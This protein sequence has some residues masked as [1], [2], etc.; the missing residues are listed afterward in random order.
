MDNENK[1]QEE[2]KTEAHKSFERALKE[3]YDIE[4]DENGI[5]K[6]EHVGFKIK[7]DFSKKL[8]QYLDTKPMMESEIWCNDIENMLAD[9]DSYL[10]REFMQGFIKYL[11]EKCP[12]SEVKE[13]VAELM[14]EE[15]SP[16]EIFI[17]HKNKNI[18]Q[19]EIV[20]MEFMVAEMDA[21]QEEIKKQNQE[22]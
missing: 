15:N 18:S 21:S 10:S 7:P 1:N 19:E 9:N 2:L 4:L 20:E 8:I 14:K 22:E 6:S 13:F 16:L 11:Q 17:F 3:K 12:R 5:I